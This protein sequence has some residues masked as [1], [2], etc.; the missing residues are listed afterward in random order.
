[1]FNEIK[2]DAQPELRPE[3]IARSGG[4]ST[5]PQIF[6]NDQHIGGC[7]DLH[8]LDAQGRLDTLLQL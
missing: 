2:I 7:D 1:M 8:A 6:I 3:M 4:R 5:V